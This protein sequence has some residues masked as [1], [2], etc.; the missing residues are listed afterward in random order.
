MPEQENQNYGCCPSNSDTECC[1]VVA[2]VTVDKKGQILLPKDL[3]DTEDI[4]EGDRFTIINVNP[5][6]KQCVLI[7]MKANLLEPMVQEAL[8]PVLEIIVRR[9]NTEEYQEKEEL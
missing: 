7:L 8:S 2:L 4:K 9:E 3:R 6:G 5:G 1:K